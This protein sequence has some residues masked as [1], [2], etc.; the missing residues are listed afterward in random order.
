MGCLYST[1]SKTWY[2]ILRRND[3]QAV[4]EFVI[5]VKVACCSCRM[6][7]VQPEIRFGE[8]DDNSRVK[9]TVTWTGA[10]LSHVVITVTLALTTCVQTGL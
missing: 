9:Q 1:P 2:V 10:L 8:L 5:V 3:D 7:G 4:D 6:H